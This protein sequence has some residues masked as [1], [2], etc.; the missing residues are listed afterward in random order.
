MD[1]IDLIRKLA[2]IFYRKT[3][4]EFD[5]LFSEAALAYAEALNN[6]DPTHNTK[7]TSYA[8]RCMYNHLINTCKK[9]ARYCNRHSLI[10]DHIRAEN[11]LGFSTDDLE[12]TLSVFLKKTGHIFEPTDDFGDF[13]SECS[14]DCFQVI[15]MVLSN[16]EFFLGETPEMRRKK[17]TPKQRVKNALR[18]DNWTHIKIKYTLSEVDDFISAL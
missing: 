15:D 2:W 8:Y 10:E 12:E 3:D 7:L 9:K 18:Q 5:E 14:E 4:I 11:N 16:P 6:F 13:I 1:N 17:G